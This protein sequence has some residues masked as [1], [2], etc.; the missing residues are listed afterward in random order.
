M[1]TTILVF[2]IATVFVAAAVD[3]ASAQNGSGSG[4]ALCDSATATTLECL[5]YNPY[6]VPPGHTAHIGFPTGAFGSP[7]YFASAKALRRQALGES[8]EQ[9]VGSTAPRRRVRR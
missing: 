7:E 2:A 3:G 4:R 9:Y 8:S 1:R 5:A 6:Y